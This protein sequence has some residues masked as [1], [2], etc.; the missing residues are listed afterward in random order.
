MHRNADDDSS[1][2]GGA[3]SGSACDWL[4][5]SRYTACCNVAT[6]STAMGGPI[7]GRKSSSFLSACRCG[8]T[9]R[10]GERMQP[11]G[12]DGRRRK[13]QDVMVDAHGPGGPA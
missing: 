5:N 4:G 1:L 2:F 9:R 7:A 12:M 10:D 3:G 8:C 6:G 13:L 11:L